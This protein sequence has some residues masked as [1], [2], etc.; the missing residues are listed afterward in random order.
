MGTKL[1]RANEV[2]SAVSSNCE[3]LWESILRGL[4]LWLRVS[5]VCGE[6][7]GHIGPIGLLAARFLAYISLQD[8]NHEVAATW[9]WNLGCNTEHSWTLSCSRRS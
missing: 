5:S 6:L 2:A 4:W 8:A 1:V 7:V 9:I 3:C